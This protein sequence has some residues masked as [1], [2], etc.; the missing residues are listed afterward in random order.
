M[1]RSYRGG[2]GVGDGAAPV[3]MPIGFGATGGTPGEDG[4]L[5]GGASGT[6]WPD[7]GAPGTG[8]GDRPI[9]ACG[10]GGCGSGVRGGGRAM[11]ISAWVMLLR[12]LL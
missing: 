12:W 7:G 6:G 10:S 11:F 1:A 8:A 3:A 2:I 4:M 9:P 5:V